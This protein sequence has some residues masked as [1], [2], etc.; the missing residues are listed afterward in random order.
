M[1]SS[2]SYIQNNCTRNFINLKAN[3]FSKNINQ[4][5]STTYACKAQGPCILCCRCS[6]IISVFSLLVLA[7]QYNRP[8]LLIQQA[9]S[10]LRLVAQ[11][12]MVSVT[13]TLSYPLHSNHIQ[14]SMQRVTRT[15]SSYPLHI[16]QCMELP[17]SLH[18]H[19]R[20]Q[21]KKL[22]THPYEN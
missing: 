15:T 14:L 4:L 8:T 21:H 19:K 10:F 16:N 1:S 22:S 2:Q 9:N 5:A 11:N 18:I 12:S 3:Y 6:L 20:R 7:C 13:L 17:T